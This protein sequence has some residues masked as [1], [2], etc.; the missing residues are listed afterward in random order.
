MAHVRDEIEAELDLLRCAET[1]PGLSEVALSLAEAI[2]KNDSATG[3]ANA[4]QALRAVM[5]DL[6]KYAPVEAKGDAVDD[7]AEQRAKRRA[8]AREQAAGG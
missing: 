6:R 4:A 7:I 1:A 5:T 8:A 3:R 2:D